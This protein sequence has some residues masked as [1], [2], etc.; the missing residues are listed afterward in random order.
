MLR[1]WLLLAAL[2]GS[3]AVIDAVDLGDLLQ[4][5]AGNLTLPAAGARLDDSSTPIT[6]P[7]NSTV[8]LTGAGDGTLTWGAS[9]APRLALEPGEATQASCSA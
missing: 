8:W 3:V 4:R 5:A 9:G 1:L 7:A 6:I 2:V